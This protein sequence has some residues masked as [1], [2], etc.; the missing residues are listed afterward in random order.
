SHCPEQR[1]CG[2]LLEVHPKPFN[3][4]PSEPEIRTFSAQA[5]EK[6]KTRSWFSSGKRALLPILGPVRPEQLSFAR[7][8]LRDRRDE[9]GD[10]DE[11]APVEV[12][13]NG[14]PL[15]CPAAHRERERQTV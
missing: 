13:R 8:V 3:S 15:P 9:V 1:L 6:T 7:L 11:A 12:F 5:P 10:V 2:V 14:V 4:A